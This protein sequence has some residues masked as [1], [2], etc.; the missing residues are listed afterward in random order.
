ML[1]AINNQNQPFNERFIFAR[2]FSFNFFI[3]FSPI[4]FSFFC[5]PQSTVTS[6]IEWIFKR[7]KEQKEYFCIENKQKK[8]SKQNRLTEPVYMDGMLAVFAF[9]EYPL[10]QTYKVFGL[11]FPFNNSIQ[12]LI[13]G[14][15]KGK[16]SK[17]SLWMALSYCW[18]NRKYSQTEISQTNIHLHWHFFFSVLFEFPAPDWE[19][20]KK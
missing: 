15:E 5:G 18:T 14:S 6:T 4:F 7:K 3:R 1:I 19:K 16:N 11:G 10:K 12:N 20:I 13:N 2:F 17:S 9:V 8:T